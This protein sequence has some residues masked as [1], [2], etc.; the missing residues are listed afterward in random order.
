MTQSRV[1]RFA[2]R[3]VEPMLA[4][5]GCMPAQRILV[6]GAKSVE[7]VLD[8]QRRGFERAAATANCGSPE[9]QYD[10]ALVDWR[11]RTF[12]AFE[13]TLDW[14]MDFLTPAAVVVVWLDPQKPAG[15][16]NLRAALTQRG[17][18]VDDGK[19]REDGCVVLARRAEMPPMSR[20]A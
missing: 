15:M 6:A 1:N 7:I 9:R 13:A 14:L 16:A 4:L 20:A 3:T 18:R 8:L 11:Q 19:L 5:A 2:E 12:K 10:V 17:L